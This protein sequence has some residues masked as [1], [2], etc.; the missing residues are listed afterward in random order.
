MLL[1]NGQV[2]IVATGELDD[3]IDLYQSPVPA[4]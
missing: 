1:P 3:P 2:L 4:L